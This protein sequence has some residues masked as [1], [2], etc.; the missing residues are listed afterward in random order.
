MN[1]TILLFVHQYQHHHGYP[2]SVREIAAHIRRARTPTAMRIHKLI[3]D[4][5]LEQPLD[6]DGGEARTLRRTL[7]LTPAGLA[8]IGVVPPPATWPLR[9]FV[10]RVERIGTSVIF[11]IATSGAG[12]IQ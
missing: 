2:P 5:L 3:A 7:R 1:N 4:G 10:Q 9:D 8:A 11:D 12:V 6:T